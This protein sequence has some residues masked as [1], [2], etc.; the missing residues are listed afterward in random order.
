MSVCKNG[1]GIGKLRV[2]RRISW[3]ALRPQ[4]FDD[5]LAGE[6]KKFLAVLFAY[7]EFFM[8]LSFGGSLRPELFT[9]VAAP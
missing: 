7:A 3:H 8:G 1:R 4:V 2:A 6:H 9:K 5:G